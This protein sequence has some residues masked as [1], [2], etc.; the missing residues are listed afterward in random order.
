MGK[1]GNLGSKKL[2]S[3][4]AVRSSLLKKSS[5][6]AGLVGVP[7][8]KTWSAEAVIAAETLAVVARGLV[9]SRGESIDEEQLNIRSAIPEFVSDEEKSAHV[10][11][12]KKFVVKILFPPQNVH[13]KSIA[14]PSTTPKQ[15]DNQTSSPPSRMGDDS[16]GA[17][18][19]SKFRPNTPPH[20]K[21]A[22]YD[23]S[24]LPLPDKKGWLKK[25]GHTTHM[26]TSDYKNR[27][28]ELNS[29]KGELTYYGE[30]IPDA[31]MGDGQQNEEVEE[32]KRK[33][34]KGTVDLS[35][36]HELRPSTTKRAP[37]MAFDLE[38]ESRTW[39]IVPPSAS[40]QESWLTLYARSWTRRPCQK[41]TEVY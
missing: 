1:P 14:S 26:L 7:S 29:A 37:K 13:K 6:G 38:T 4:V 30:Q 23:E 10:K 40:D 35:I 3:A 36:V 2:G 22:D 39:I 21:D 15:E 9:S 17:A 19:E 25:R 28:F 20:D 34:I 41:S 32:A 16:A 8:P 24:A 27:W 5:I 11:S 12:G 31:V 18:E 33:N